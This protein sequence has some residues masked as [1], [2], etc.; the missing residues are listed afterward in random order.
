MGNRS[1]NKIVAESFLEEYEEKMK[2]PNFGKSEHRGVNNLGGFRF[3]LKYIWD[4]IVEFRGFIFAI[5]FNIAFVAT[6]II[7][8]LPY[9]SLAG[10]ALTLAL[11]IGVGATIASVTYGY[12]KSRMRIVKAIR[13]VFPESTKS[14]ALRIASLIR[15]AREEEDKKYKELMRYVIEH[16]ISYKK[17]PKKEKKGLEKATGNWLIR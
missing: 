2:D 14:Q 15:K 10:I 17:T 3:T 7:I 16:N 11:M 8:G 9:E 4:G 1:Y 13:K 6:A 5:L 12:F